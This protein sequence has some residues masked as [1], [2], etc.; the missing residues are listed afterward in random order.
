MHAEQRIVL[1]KSVGAVIIR[2]F[3][4]RIAATVAADANIIPVN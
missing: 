2:L 1:S 4:G 3:K